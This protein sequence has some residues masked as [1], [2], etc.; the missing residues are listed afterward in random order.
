MYMDIELLIDITLIYNTCLYC[1]Q[2]TYFNIQHMTIYLPFF[3]YRTMNV[4]QEK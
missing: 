4:I 3:L 2:S 1:I